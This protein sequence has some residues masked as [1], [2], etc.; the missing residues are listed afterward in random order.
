MS[1]EEAKSYTHVSR[2][3][4]ALTL[5][6]MPVQ[7]L[8]R[9]HQDGVLGRVSS[10]FALSSFSF[11]GL[12]GTPCRGFLGYGLGALHG[13]RSYCDVLPSSLPKRKREKSATCLEKSLL[14][15][16][17]PTWTSKASL[18]IQEEP[19]WIK[20]N[21]PLKSSTLF[22]CKRTRGKIYK[23]GKISGK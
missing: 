10:S 8:S 2:E 14:C 21:G 7:A 3:W 1:G 4:S 18:R 13:V 17:Y 11:V 23:P 19:S 12:S 5:H 16:S 6:S 22:S 9:V 15:N 20:A